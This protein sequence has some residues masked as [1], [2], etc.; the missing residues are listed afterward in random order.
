ME[1][2]VLT[3]LKKFLEKKHCEGNTRQ[4]SSFKSLLQKSTSSVMSE[5]SSMSIRTIIYMAAVA[6][7][8]V[9]PLIPES[10]SKAYLEVALSFGFMDDISA[11]L[12]MRGRAAYISELGW[13]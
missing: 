12:R 9:I 5:N 8:G 7:K 1:M 10:F 11:S 4:H 2:K 6:F 13:S 3:I